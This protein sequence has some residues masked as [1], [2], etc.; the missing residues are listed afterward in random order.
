MQLILWTVII[1]SA[2]STLALFR[3]AHGGAGTDALN[4][5][6]PEQVW[7]LLGLSGATTAAALAIKGTK[8]NVGVSAQEDIA[9]QKQ[10]GVVIEQL[11]AAAG[12]VGHVGALITNKGPKGA[13]MADLFSGDEVGDALYVDPGKIQMFFFTV[14][15]AI[16]YASAVGDV[17]A[18]QTPVADAFLPDL[19]T[20]M[21]T[22]LGISQAGYLGTK[23]A[24]STS[25]TLAD[26][27]PP[28]IEIVAPADKSQFTV[29]ELVYAGYSCKD[30]EGGSGVKS[31]T[32][33]V[34]SGEP[35]D[36]QKVGSYTFAVTAEDKAGNIENKIHTYTVT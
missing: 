1:V 21:V 30:E 6:V 15:V 8:K 27:M 25:T 33:S 36:T 24:S 7:A 12:N 26:T 34:P 29:D 13:S 23:Y 20:G 31:C 32:G 11:P 9:I 3:L 18:D 16:A 4:I 5:T 2:L 14:L 22:L 10:L 35:I 17:F 19:S 28:T